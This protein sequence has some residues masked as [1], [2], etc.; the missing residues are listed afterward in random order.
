MSKIVYF[1]GSSKCGTTSLHSAISK[2][3]DVHAPP[4]KEIHYWSWVRPPFLKESTL[5]KRLFEMQNPFTRS[6]F[7]AASTINP[8][9]R[10]KYVRLKFY[11]TML[12]SD[13]GNNAAYLEYLKWGRGKEPVTVDFTPN[14]CLLGKE[15]FR[16]MAALAEDT[17]FVFIMRDPVERLWSS[18][19]FENRFKAWHAEK[20]RA[21]LNARLEYAL[22]DPFDNLVRK[23]RYDEIIDR[24]ESS[25]GS[26]NCLYLFYENLFETEELNKL[27]SW[28][29]ISPVEITA[30]EPLNVGSF[31]KLA[32]FDHLLKAAQRN[33]APTYNYVRQRFGTRVP[34]GWW[35]I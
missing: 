33:F 20:A 23:S 7:W 8:S 27:S 10:N 2:N 9:W 4:G 19:R 34:N 12:S 11:E 35:A 13:I 18:I 31:S 26:Q 6:I 32:P 14:Y 25:V 16:E 1:I 5:Q 17:K 22:S 28:L 15:T 30:S 3:P 24:L 29:G 21:L